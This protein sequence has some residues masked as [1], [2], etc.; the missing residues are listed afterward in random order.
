MKRICAVYRSSRTEG[1]YLYVDHQEDLSRVP[2]D[3][4]K[5]F[6]QPQRSMTLV[7]NAERKLARADVNKV[8]AEI[9]EKGFYLQLPPQPESLNPRVVP[10]ADY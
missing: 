10:E 8:M 5:R 6:G 3:L 9:A 7:L 2:E 4:L 1:M